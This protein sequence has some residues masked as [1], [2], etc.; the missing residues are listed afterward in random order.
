MKL[1]LVEDAKPL[2]RALA[3]GL[4]KEGYLVDVSGEGREGLWLAQTN[5]YDLIILDLMLPGLDGLSLLQQLRA[6]GNATHVL[7]LTA[8]DTVEDRVMGLRTGA[9]DYLVKPF[10]F[11]EL[12]AR[13]QALCR[14][15]YGQKQSRLVVGALELDM[16][17]KTVQCAGR[18]IRLKPREF[19]LLELL[20]L[21]QGELV[22]R[23]EIE[24]HLYDATANPMSNV[25]D[26]AIC[27]LRKK[28]SVSGSNP[29]IHT[30]HGLGYV[31]E[32]R[33]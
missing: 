24:A 22:S 6:K 27:S 23:T 12:L 21:R 32:N 20:M 3:T 1:L 31:L 25:V 26:S 7:V 30:R 17:D 19:A 18:P 10:A 2:Q 16:A 28:L 29:L 8:K 9:D 11:E 13:V 14:R 4:R 5:E 15:G 33:L